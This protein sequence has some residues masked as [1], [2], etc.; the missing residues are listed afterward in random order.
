MILT[1]WRHGEAED[2]AVDRSRRL[3]SNGR[4]DIGF[5]CHQFHDACAARGIPQPRCVLFSPWVRTQ[6][7][8]EIISA[9]F[10]GAIPTVE[11]AL[12]PDSN[13]PTVETMLSRRAD[14]VD[15]HTI[16]VSHQPL[17]SAVVDHLLGET[18]RVPFLS[19]GG[20][21]T[22]QLDAVGQGCAELLF[23]ALAPEYEAGV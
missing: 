11:T 5:A 4:D 15:N 20:L 2:A 10:A 14:S 12:Q 16:L 9:A 3:T 21:A 23:W 8:A 22:L 17:V 6:Q 19:P 18:R 13:V 7:T 1:I